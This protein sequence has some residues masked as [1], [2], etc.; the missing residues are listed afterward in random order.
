M[1]IAVIVGIKGQ[2]GQ[3]LLNYLKNH[4]YSVIGFDINYSIS[5]ENQWRD[6]LSI[7]SFNDVSHFIKTTKP[8]EIYY[9]AAYH[10]S[11]EDRIDNEIELLNKSYEINVLSYANFL[12]AVRMY[13]NKTKLFYAASCHIFGDP[14]NTRQ[15]ENTV[16]NPM[17]AY[18]MT[19]YSGLKL[20]EYYRNKFSIF[21]S[22]GILY[23]HESE[24]RSDKFVSK[25]IVKT[26]VEIK[27]KVKNKLVIGNLDAEIDWGYAADFVEAFVKILKC[28]VPEN[29]IIATGQIQKLNDFI[30]YVFE[31]LELDWQNYVRQ[32]GTLLT[33][34]T[35]G[36]Y[37]GD[38]NKLKK[39]TGWEPKTVLKTIAE[40]M[41]DYQ[42]KLK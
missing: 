42:L 40:L 29:F 25:K 27:N 34:S 18:S 36:I 31:Y 7:N 3:F 33:R 24:L 11:S 30:Q 35:N 13:S 39:M 41:V 4:N 17:S 22:V 37:C 28:E 38:Y 6:K 2:D 16:Y 1:K 10:H 23:N 12:E 19:K 9:L 15:N 5:T 32:D 14:A 21:A 20:S 26:A 8:D